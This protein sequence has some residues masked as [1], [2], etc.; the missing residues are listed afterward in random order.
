MSICVRRLSAYSRWLLSRMSMIVLPVAR[1]F[2][3]S[4]PMRLWITVFGTG[5]FAPPP[6][7]S[8][9][10]GRQ[11]FYDVSL[12]R[13]LG[14]GGSGRRLIRRDWIAVA[15]RKPRVLRGHNR[16]LLVILGPA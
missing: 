8:R 3:G 4:R 12:L 11:L 16:E 6:A 15:V 5:Q 13:E 9:P 1:P 10:A 14:G 7:D 2:G